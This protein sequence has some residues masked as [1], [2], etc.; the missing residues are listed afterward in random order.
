MP[1]VVKCCKYMII[2]TISQILIILRIA[3]NGNDLHKSSELFP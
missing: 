2:Q 1:N 3:K